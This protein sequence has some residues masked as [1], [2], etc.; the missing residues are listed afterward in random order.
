MGRST[1]VSGRRRMIAVVAVI[2]CLALATVA[3]A[4]YRILNGI[5]LT[6]AIF[7]LVSTAVILGLAA[8]LVAPLRIGSAT[9]PQSLVDIAIMLGL[10]MLPTSWL[11]VVTAASITAAKIIARQRPWQILF[12]AGKDVMTVVVATLVGVAIGMHMPF[13]PTAAALPGLAAMAAAMICFDELVTAPVAGL[14]GGRR[15]RDGILVRLFTAVLRLG[16][17]IGAGWLL[18]HN[19]RIAIAVPM[20]A[21]GLYL[22]YANQWELRADRLAWRRLSQIVDA[23]G[24]NDDVAV[25]RAAVVGATE[26]FGCDEV[27]LL[28]H[29][30]HGGVTLLRASGGAIAYEGPEAGAP[31]T[32]G[33]VVVA[34]LDRRDPDEDIDVV[35]VRLPTTHG[36][37]SQAATAATGTNRQVGGRASVATPP[38]TRITDASPVWASAE[39]VT[40][41]WASSARGDITNG[42]TTNGGSPNGGTT[43]GTASNGTSSNGTASNGAKGSRRGGE[44]STSAAAAGV[45][46]ATATSPF[47]RPQ[48]AVGRGV[49]GELRL[50][51]RT[52]PQFGER[53]EYMLRAL[54]AALGT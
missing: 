5:V 43:N 34:D 50:R 47:G 39:D 33:T 4:T 40:T 30:P 38:G 26:L 11:I 12:A 21:L 1:Q 13:T 19:A 44:R 15:A 46:S 6:P 14:L 25:R 54:A 10:M 22:R 37:R 41:A 45:G 31:P 20:L 48:G 8:F 27:D 24:A 32:T 29:M 9:Y 28:L 53:E 18:R 42:T 52:A 49:L 36:R 3:A 2:T 7:D 17:A 51:F 35:T 23:L 16:F